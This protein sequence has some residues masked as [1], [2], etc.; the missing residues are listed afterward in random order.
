MKTALTKKIALSLALLLCVEGLAGCGSKLEQE[1]CEAAMDLYSISEK[2]YQRNFEVYDAL[3]YRSGMYDGLYDEAEPES[4]REEGEPGWEPAKTK[5]TEAEILREVQEHDSTVL[6]VK[7]GDDYYSNFL[8]DETDD[9]YYGK[10]NFSMGM[11]H[12]FQWS[13]PDVSYENGDS[14]VLFTNRELKYSDRVFDFR[15]SDYVGY[16]LPFT[17]KQRNG[18]YG[19]NSAGEV[20]YKSDVEMYEAADGWENSLADGTEGTPGDLKVLEINGTPY[21]ESPHY[22]C[23][24]DDLCFGLSY[25]HEYVIIG[26]PDEKIT[27]G[28]NDYNYYSE[29]LEHSYRC[30][31]QF[32]ALG[33]TFTSPSEP[34][35]GYAAEWKGASCLSEKYARPTKDNFTIVSNHNTQRVQPGDYMLE[36]YPIRIVD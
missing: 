28:G 36:G 12:G 32:Y 29:H 20:Y 21:Y 34:R 1:R 18:D 19:Y 22:Y 14:I 15:T 11:T 10:I 35:N 33:A 5:F 13:W 2:E 30:R 25:Y 23:V 7:K 31:D 6:A 27:L 24:R 8:F 9:Y 4:D 26:E 3:V 16:C 17:F